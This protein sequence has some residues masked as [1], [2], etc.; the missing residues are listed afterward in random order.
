M[1]NILRRWFNKTMQQYIMLLRVVIDLLMRHRNHL[2][3][4]FTDKDKQDKAKKKQL[5]DLTNRLGE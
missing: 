1:Q 3:V 5:L 2:A 4:K